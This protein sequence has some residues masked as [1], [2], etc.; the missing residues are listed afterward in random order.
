MN[1]GSEIAP[2]YN[3]EECEVWTRDDLDTFRRSIRG[4]NSPIIHLR[5]RCHVDGGVVAFYDKRDGTLTLRCS[6]CGEL[7]ST[8]QIAGRTTRK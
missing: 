4:K 3:S 2:K 1:I 5:P 6:V 8:L 7:I